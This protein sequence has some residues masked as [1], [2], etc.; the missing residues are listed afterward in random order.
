MEWAMALFEWN[1][2]FSIGIPS[3]DGEHKKI[4][5]LLN[6]LHD[7]MKEGKGKVVLG[8]VFNELVSYTKTHFATEERYFS[9]FGYPEAAGHRA[10]HHALTQKAVALRDDFASG[11]TVL[12]SDVLE[13]L[14]DWLKHHIGG[15]DKAYAPF[16][17]AK[18]VK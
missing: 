14:R 2:S 7:A 15:S 8:P 18:G 9:A 11:K 17:I 1:D 10:E 12:T 4:V 13:F 3:I 5:D 16:L 6:R